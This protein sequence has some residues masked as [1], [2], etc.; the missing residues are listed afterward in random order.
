M[1]PQVRKI[2]ALIS[3]ADKFAREEIKSKEDELLVAA[4][5]MAVVRGMYVNALGFEEASMIFEGI[6]DSFRLI[7][8]MEQ[9]C[10]KPTI[11]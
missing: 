6:A 3:K 1:D 11:H 10:P 8:Y 5:M 9:T 2:Q 7:D 4:A